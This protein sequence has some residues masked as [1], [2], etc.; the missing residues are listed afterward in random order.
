MGP[1]DDQAC[2]MIIGSYTL[3]LTHLRG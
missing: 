2:W 1:G 3:S